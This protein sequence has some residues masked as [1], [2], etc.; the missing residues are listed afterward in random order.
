MSK[1][2]E[3]PTNA[4]NSHAPRVSRGVIQIEATETGN[5]LTMTGAFQERSERAVYAMAMALA[6]MVQTVASSGNAGHTRTAPIV[7]KEL[8]KPTVMSPA[9][10][11]PTNFGELN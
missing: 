11:T 1:L 8:P 4:K 5:E 7:R 6:H 2:Y 3:F 10:Q 9:L